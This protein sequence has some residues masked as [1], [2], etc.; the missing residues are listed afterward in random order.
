MGE[1]QAHKTIDS[2]PSQVIRS[3]TD[4]EA[5]VRWAPVDFELRELRCARLEAGSTARVAGHLAGREVT[6]QI[7]VFEADDGRL[8]L[9]ASGPVVVD[10][11][12]EVERDGDAAVLTARMSTRS[13]GGITGKVL[14]TAADALA[15]GL[16][17]LA[18]DRIRRDVELA[19]A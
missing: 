17:E 19:S 12:Y 18:V 10:V 8:A 16:L 3:L 4:P 7:E 9:R 1:F 5:A 11:E 13:G 15:G 6:F 14:S 2:R